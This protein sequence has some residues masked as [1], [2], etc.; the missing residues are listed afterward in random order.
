MLID[1]ASQIKSVKARAETIQ[2]PWDQWVLEWDLTAD[3]VVFDVGAFTGRWALQIA[4]RYNPRLF[5][6]EPQEWAADVARSVLADYNAR[7]YPYGLSDQDEK[8][9]MGGF[10]TN[11]CGIFREGGHQEN[12]AFRE[13]G[14]GLEALGI[15]KIDLMM[16]NVEGHEHTLIPHMMASDLLPDTLIVQFHEL[17]GYTEADTRPLLAKAYEQQWDFGPIAAFGKGHVNHAV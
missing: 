7:V 4:Q 5:C 3:S 16:L 12:G 9:T 11:G 10:G 17:G 13:L 1:K 6:F 8:R 15:N 14:W 2:H